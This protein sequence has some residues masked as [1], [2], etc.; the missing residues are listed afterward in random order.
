MQYW[1]PAG[2]FAGDM[3]PYWDGGQFHLFYLLDHDHHAQQ[4]GLGG[5]QWAHAST[6]DL[7]T[8]QHH[9]LA[10]PIGEPGRVDQHGICTGSIFAWEGVYHAFYATRIRRAD[11]TV[12]EAVCRAAGRDLVHFDRSPDNPLFAAGEGLD[13]AHHRDPFVFHDPAAG[14]F[15]MLVTAR[16]ADAPGRPGRGA[17]GS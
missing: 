10:L 15:H 2:A 13:P 12:Y 8:W 11:G 9:P 3:M 4:G 14:L 7:V 1:R 5:H 6:A 17:R 16:E